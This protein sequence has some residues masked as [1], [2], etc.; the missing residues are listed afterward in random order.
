MKKPLFIYGAG[1]LGREILSLI[2]AL[3]EWKVEGFLDDFV[4]E[5]TFIK[6]IPVMG[7]V[8]FINSLRQPS[9]VVLA[10]GEPHV[11]SVILKSIVNPNIFFP[12]FIH[13]MA[14]LQDRSSIHIGKGVVIGAGCVLTTDIIIGDHVLINLNTTVGH[15]VS[16][17]RYT[18]VMPGVNISGNVSIGDGVLIGSGSG[19]RNKIALGD[20]CVVGMGSVVINSV[21]PGSV[22]AGVPAKVLTHG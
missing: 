19:I 16:I 15:D 18:S 6:G 3:D 22:V 1:G 12:S 17:G 13:P 7:G 14:I 20:R 21:D 9:N 2:S 5:R 4:A 8:S 11:K 10:F